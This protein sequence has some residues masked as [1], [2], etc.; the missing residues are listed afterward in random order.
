MWRVFLANIEPSLFATELKLRLR[1]LETSVLSIAAA[2]WVTWPCSVGLTKRLDRTQVHMTA[3]IIYYPHNSGASNEL[4]YKHRNMLAG[5]HSAKS[6]WSVK[7]ATAVLA[8]HHHC[9][10]PLDSSM[11][12]KAIL[13]HHDKASWSLKGQN[14]ATALLSVHVPVHQQGMYQ[15]DGVNS[16]N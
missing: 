4:Y 8:W 7:W 5:K 15:P 2:R 10:N 11:W 12:H 14:L 3:I 9:I 6:R 1:W 13:S 16:L